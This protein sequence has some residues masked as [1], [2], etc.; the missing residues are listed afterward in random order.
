MGVPDEAIAADYAAS[1][2]RLWP[3]FRRMQADAAGDPARLA[4]L[5]HKLPTAPPE[6]MLAVLE[7]LRQRYG[8]VRAYLL[9]AGLTDAELARIEQRLVER[10]DQ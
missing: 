7:H 1:E 10:I 6:A 2:E 3:L 4:A 9:G 8:G 5:Q